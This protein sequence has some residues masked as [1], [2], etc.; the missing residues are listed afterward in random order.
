MKR[1]R[2]LGL[3]LLDLIG[4]C[5]LFVLAVGLA[6]VAVPLALITVGSLL[7]ACLLWPAFLAS[8]RGK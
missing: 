5:G 4:I 3:D 1:L 8:W 6:L 7:T 2:A